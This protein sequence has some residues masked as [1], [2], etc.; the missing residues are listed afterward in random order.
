[1][2]GA[3]RRRHGER[4]R[5]FVRRRS[6]PAQADRTRQRP[7]RRRREPHR[8]QAGTR[9]NEASIRQARHEAAT[10]TDA[11]PVDTI[12]AQFPILAQKIHGR[13]LAYLDNAATT[14]VPTA[15]MDAVREFESTIRANIHRG[16]HTLSQEST[17]AFE[18]ARTDLA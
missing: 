1:G 14:Q 13:P 15:V 3:D 8:T 10:A 11:Y 7:A 5:E 4:P 18:R 9:M 6:R 12:R 16:V 17:D 2:P